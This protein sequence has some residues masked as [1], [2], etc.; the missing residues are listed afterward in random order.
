MRLTLFYNE[1]EIFGEEMEAQKVTVSISSQKSDEEGVFLT[2]RTPGKVHALFVSFLVFG[3]NN[4]NLLLVFHV[5][6][7]MHIPNKLQA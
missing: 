5:H 1:G 6:M 4:I 2:I 7:I 3:L